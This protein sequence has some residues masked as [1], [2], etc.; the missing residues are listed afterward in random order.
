[1][2]DQVADA[3]GGVGT[4]TRLGSVS[5]L[6]TTSVRG[7]RRVVTLRETNPVFGGDGD[8]ASADPT[9]RATAPPAASGNDTLVA[10]SA[11]DARRPLRRRGRRPSATGARLAAAQE[12]SPCSGACNRRRGG[13]F[14]RERAVDHFRR[15]VRLTS[16]VRLSRFPRRLP[17]PG[18]HRDARTSCAF[19]TRRR[20]AIPDFFAA[21]DGHAGMTQ[22]AV[23][24]AGTGFVLAGSPNAEAIAAR[25]L[26]V[27]AESQLWTG[28]AA[29][30]IRI[31]AGGNDVFDGGSGND[32]LDGMS[33]DDALSGGGVTTCFSGG[34]T[35]RDRR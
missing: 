29:A 24:Q 1:M 34:R 6:L 30:E 25:A 31:G 4:M 10:G 22:L 2:G 23:V 5:V 17:R 35:R 9:S 28:N 15:R 14:A 27:P 21:G 3:I 19:A 16:D 11:N 33:G 12:R 8:D 32:E 18:R 20:V 7:R 26:A 13:A